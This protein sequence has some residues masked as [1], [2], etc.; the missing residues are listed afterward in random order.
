[1][2]KR[3]QRE[4]DSR[5]DPCARRSLSP[6]ESLTFLFR[7]ACSRVSDLWLL[8]SSSERVQAQRRKSPPRPLNFVEPRVTDASKETGSH[9]F[10]VVMNR[11]V[12]PPPHTSA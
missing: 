11:T 6:L 8:T 3:Q 5:F 2:R 7:L 10:L 1:M 4:S 9:S 12:P